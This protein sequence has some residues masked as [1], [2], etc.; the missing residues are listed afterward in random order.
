MKVQFL[1]LKMEA[2]N[3]SETLVP[4][5]PTSDTMVYETKTNICSVDI[6]CLL[7]MNFLLFTKNCHI[8]RLSYNSLHQAKSV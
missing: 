1:S 6:N 8:F 7:V 5:H 4:T 2:T 3:F